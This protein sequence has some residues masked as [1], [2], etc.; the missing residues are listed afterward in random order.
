MTLQCLTTSTQKMVPALTDTI[1]ARQLKSMIDQP[2]Q[3]KPMI[4]IFDVK[5]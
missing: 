2:T 3:L 1:F 4:D 5:D